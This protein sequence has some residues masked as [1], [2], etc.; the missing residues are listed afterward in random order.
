M[1]EPAADN[2]A[3]TDYSRRHFLKATLATGAGLGVSLGGGGLG[4]FAAEGAKPAEL[5]F[6]RSDGALQLSL[7]PRLVLRYQVSAPGMGGA[8]V[9]SGCY[10]H[11]LCTPSG[12]VVTEVG[13][14]DH[15]HHRGAFFGWV[16]MHG[17]ADADFWGWG[18]RAPIKG[19]KIVNRALE[20]PQP[21]LGYARFRAVNDWMAGDK[22][23]LSEDL[24]VGTS[25]RDGA[26]VLDIAVQYTVEEEVT[27]ARSGFGGFAVRGRK[28]GQ[29]SAIGA[30]GAVTLDPP[31]HTEPDTNW[32]AAQ[33]YGLSFKYPDGKKA[34]VV[35]V[36]RAA[37]PATTWHVAPSIGLINPCITA[38]GPLTLVPGKPLSL[39]Y[40][41]MAF[42]GS[43]AP[44][45][46][47]PSAD[48]WYRGV[49][50]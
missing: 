33:W 10:L 43:P 12:V 19:R 21:A 27:L 46:V 50:G 16:E 34:T 11:P 18:E 32:P 49:P 36:G 26:T 37:N 29:A 44:E 8:A 30:S 42:D 28:D 15:R 3:A 17:A 35:V 1:H 2:R 20:A 23:V 9:E 31:K 45:V 4:A 40:R 25:M 38:Q 13:P 48:A 39:R 47:N 22:K 6:A 14:D 7:G 41:V 24:R 5:A